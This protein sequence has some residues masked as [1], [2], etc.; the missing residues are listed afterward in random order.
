MQ[1]RKIIVAC[2]SVLLVGLALPSIPRA[3]AF[4]AFPP[5][6]VTFTGLGVSG[7]TDPVSGT[8]VDGIAAGSTLTVNVYLVASSGSALTQYQRNV[9]V[10]YKGDWMSAYQNA[11]NAN[12]TSTLSMTSG[13]VATVTISVVTPTTGGVAPHSWSVAVWDGASNSLNAATC[14]SQFDRGFNPDKQGSPLAVPPACDLIPTTGFNSLAIYT[15]DQLSAAQA[16]V[17]ANNVIGNVQTQ[18]TAL[19]GGFLHNAPPGVTAAAGQLAQAQTE[20]ALGGQSWHNGDYSGAKSHYQNALNDANAAAA[21][22]TGQ[23]GADSASLVN[24]LLGGTGLALI[25]IGALFAGLGA[26]FFLRR[27]PKA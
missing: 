14:L 1:R 21:S 20:L 7:F 5:T 24:L 25:G 8:T 3:H 9:T 22:L 6:G 27:K 26:F 15:S 12:P 11:T 2:L 10:G 13:Q 16:N 4:L 17:A 19:S 23:G 18:V